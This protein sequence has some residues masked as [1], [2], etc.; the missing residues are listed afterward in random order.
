MSRSIFRRRKSA[1]NEKAEEQRRAVSFHVGVQDQLDFITYSGLEEY[2]DYLMVDGR[3]V[4]TLYVSGY[5]YTASSGWLNHLVN[6]NHNADIS[7]HIEPIEATLAAA[8]P[9]SV[10]RVRMKTLMSARRSSVNGRAPRR[11]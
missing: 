8:S 6:F 4:K 3:Y 5:P 10:T 9:L 2:P 1:R 7:Y 11:G